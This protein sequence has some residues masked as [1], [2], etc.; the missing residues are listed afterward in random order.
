MVSHAARW[1][2]CGGG[3]ITSSPVAS[4]SRC[5]SA[6]RAGSPPWAT[7]A[8]QHYLVLRSDPEPS[9]KPEVDQVR[10]ELAR[11]LGEPPMSPGLGPRAGTPGLD[12][13]LAPGVSGGCSVYSSRR[14][15]NAI[16]VS[17]IH[18][19]MAPPGRRL[20]HQEHGLLDCRRPSPHLVAF[21]A[22]PRCC[23]QLRGDRLATRPFPCGTQR[24]ARRSMRLPCGDGAVAPRTGLRLV[25]TSRRRNTN[26]RR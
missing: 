4:F 17:L 7:R 16:E 8:Y 15:G 6:K 2:R 20:P 25:Q 3:P 10:A 22:T 1:L 11:L 18:R 26:R 9:V 21:P 19:A 5:S 23:D 13:G 24:F 12:P 14:S